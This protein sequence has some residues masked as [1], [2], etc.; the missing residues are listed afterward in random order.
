VAPAGAADA[1]LH[2]FDTCVIGAAAGIDGVAVDDRGRPWVG[3]QAGD[4]IA[5]RDGDRWR[6]VIALAT[7]ENDSAG[8]FDWGA[9]ILTMARGG[10]SL[11]F[12]QF[13]RG[14]LRYTPPADP[15]GAGDWLLLSP[16]TSPMLGDA[17]LTLATHPDGVVL[18]GTDNVTFGGSPNDE[19]GV[20]VLIDQDRPRD[21]A[22]WLHLPPSRL[23]GNQ[24]R[25]I[26]VADPDVVWIAVA[27]AGLVRWDVNGRSAGPDDPLTWRDTA[28]D[29]WAGP[30]TAV[31]GTDIDLAATQALL[32]GPDGTLL[33]GG[34]GLVQL[35]YAPAL[36]LATLVDAW[37]VKD[38]A[39]TD[40]LIG[41][42][43]LGLARDRNQDVWALTSAG[44][45]RLRFG[46]QDVRLDAYTDL[47]TYFTLDPSFYAPSVIV[48]LPGGTYRDLAASATGDLLVLSSDLG[49]AQVAVPQASGDVSEDAD[50]AYLYPNPF[51]GE[52]AADRISLGGLDVD[53]E[54][55]VTVEVLNLV[56]Q[57]VYRSRDLPSAEGFWDGRNRQGRR[58]A[59]GLYLV[60]IRHGSQTLVRTLAVSY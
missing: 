59:S 30:L 27:G 28:D 36:D 17:F 13:T 60:K 33:A 34:S 18:M 12:G 51:P 19:Y 25:A 49:A 9:N 10:S 38:S 21:P 58:V 42:T 46:E 44:L 6:N 24:V 48:A 3:D 20:D 52:T 45:N 26:A 57:I 16:E 37:K 56:G 50:A 4:G 11:W 29:H 39:F 55:P 35:R 2:R 23:G 15:D 8:L 54:R 7:A 14:A 40:G 22:S 43:V 41:Q 31:D 32:P 1:T 47:E 53:A 5:G